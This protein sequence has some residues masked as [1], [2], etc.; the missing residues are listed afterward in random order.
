MCDRVVIYDISQLSPGCG[1]PF[2][3]CRVIATYEGGIKRG[4]AMPF[5]SIGRE[6]FLFVVTSRGLYGYSLSG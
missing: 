2:K 6:L 4:C 3:G 1:G 5:F